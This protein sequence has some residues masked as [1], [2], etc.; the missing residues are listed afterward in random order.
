MRHKHP[1]VF[2]EIRDLKYKIQPDGLVQERVLSLASFPGVA[3][4][5]LIKLAWEHC[6]PLNLEHV[7][8]DLA[9]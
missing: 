3:P 2:D 9:D 4:E 5:D 1:K 7:Y 6:E 8:L